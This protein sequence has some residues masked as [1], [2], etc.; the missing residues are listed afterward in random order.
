MMILFFRARQ[1]SRGELCPKVWSKK[2]IEQRA[3]VAYD[4]K[5]LSRSDDDVPAESLPFMLVASCD[6][7]EAL[8]LASG[9]APSPHTP[10]FKSWADLKIEA[11]QST[12]VCV[13]AEDEHSNVI[14]CNR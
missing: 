13:Q 3:L 8:Q 9:D 2:K 11:A 10:H 14:I 6:G 5:K 12:V 4:V 7:L 1:L